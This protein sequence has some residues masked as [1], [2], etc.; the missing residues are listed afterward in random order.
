MRRK[1]PE[2]HE[3]EIL[4]QMRMQNWSEANKAIGRLEYML[5]EMYEDERIIEKKEWTKR[6]RRRVK[7]AEK[8]G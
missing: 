7:L 2:L 4:I 1:I 3:E 6:M 5:S 8:N